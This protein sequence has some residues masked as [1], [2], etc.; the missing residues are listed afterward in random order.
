MVFVILF[1]L[2]GLINVDVICVLLAIYSYA[3]WNQNQQMKK[4]RI[5]HSFNRNLL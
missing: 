3:L 5:N 4:K 2:P 1:L